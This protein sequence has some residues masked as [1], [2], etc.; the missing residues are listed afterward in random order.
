M[1]AEAA[2]LGTPSIFVSTLTLGYLAELERQFRLVHVCSDGHA[3][4]ELAR[5]LLERHNLKAMWAERRRGMLEEKIDVTPFVA[6]Q[7]E[8][9]ARN[10][11]RLPDGV[12]Q[13]GA[14][15]LPTAAGL[16]RRL[17]DAT[18]DAGELDRAEDA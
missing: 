4:I 2:V 9:H 18:S 5:D 12:V 16:D 13:C 7:V 8:R 15:G 11:E 6:D 14:R 3:G 10:A 1:A 17:P